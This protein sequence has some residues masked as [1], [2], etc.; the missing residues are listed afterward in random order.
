[1]EN[2]TKTELCWEEARGCVGSLGLP[3]PQRAHRYCSSE[4]DWGGAREMLLG[5]MPDAPPWG[6]ALRLGNGWSSEASE[7]ILGKWCPF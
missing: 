4:G 6:R 1:M 2:Q 7:R 3:P 5:T